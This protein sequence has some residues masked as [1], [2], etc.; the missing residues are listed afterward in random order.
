MSSPTPDTFAQK[1]EQA[2]KRA[3]RSRRL[4]YGA[5]LVAAALAGVF[6]VQG[7]IHAPP[8]APEPPAP[9]KA[10]HIS[11]GFSSF[12]GIDINN[13]PFSV[14]AEQGVQDTHDETL[15]HLK[16]V[17]GAFVRREGGE[18]QVTADNADYEL[19][20]KDLIVAGHVRFEEPGRYVA[21]LSSAAVN[22]ER[23]RIVTKEPVQVETSGATV[24]A[25]SMETSEDGKLVILR[26]HVKAQFASSVVDK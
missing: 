8:T 24:S 25:D 3:L 11:G 18:V 13:K 6:I 20:T 12:S 7:V 21:F 5:A 19:K 17:I 15:M 4:G 10:P 2:R 1:A 9:E 14:K 22:L 23:Q 26:G 16:T